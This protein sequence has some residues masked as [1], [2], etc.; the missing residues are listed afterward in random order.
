MNP[1]FVCVALAAN[2][3]KYRLLAQIFVIFSVFTN[4]NK[5][6]LKIICNYI[7]CNDAIFKILNYFLTGNMI[8]IPGSLLKSGILHRGLIN[9]DKSA[10]L[11]INIFIFF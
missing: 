6:R 1:F 9:T 4:S 3:E 10:E 2:I 7:G 5:Q 11:D 8:Y